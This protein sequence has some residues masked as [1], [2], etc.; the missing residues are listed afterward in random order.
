M[1]T[2]NEEH[3]NGLMEKIKQT[4]QY[5]DLESGKIQVRQSLVSFGLPEK[6]VLKEVYVDADELE[7]VR[8]LNSIF[9]AIGPQQLKGIF[10]PFN[11]GCQ[12]TLSAVG[13]RE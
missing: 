1:G 2:E 9:D 4:E 3:R 6:M 13:E 7:N 10:A 12:P 5:K 11:G 8:L